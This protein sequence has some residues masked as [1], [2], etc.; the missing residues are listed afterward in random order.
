MSLSPGVLQGESGH[1][2][3]LLADSSMAPVSKDT[4]TSN[5]GLKLVPAG[6]LRQHQELG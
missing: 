4:G 1:S 6:A 2:G 3:L 5:F